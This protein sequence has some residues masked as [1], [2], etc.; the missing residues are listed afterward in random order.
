MRLFHRKFGFRKKADLVN[1]FNEAPK[2]IPNEDFQPPEPV[3]IKKDCLA[4]LQSHPL[5]H[6][7]QK[8][9]LQ[10]KEKRLVQCRGCRLVLNV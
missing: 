4:I 7:E 10:K 5:F 2:Q 8:T 1:L 6:Q 9:T 3:N